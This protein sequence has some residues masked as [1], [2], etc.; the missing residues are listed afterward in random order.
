MTTSAAFPTDAPL[1]GTKLRA[2][3]SIATYR[4]RPRLSARLDAALEDR[5]RLTLLSAPP[6][7]GKTVAV[8]GWLEAR[9]VPHVWLSL[10]AADNDLARFVRYVAA[11]LRSVR[12]GAGEAAAGLFVPG[13]SPSADLVGATLLDVM[14]AGDDSFILVLDD[15]QAIGSEPI[16]HLVRFLI[17]RAPPFVHPVL[18]TREDPALP[19]ARWRA[20]GQLVEL[21]ANDLRY[22]DAEAA[23]Y[24]VDAGVALTPEHVGRLV[25][26]TEGWVAGLQLAAISLRGRP[27]PASLVNAFGGSQR[28]VL[29]YLADE[30]MGWVGDDLR[31]FL[32]ETSVAERFTAE[33][34]RELT[35]REDAEAL[36]ARAETSNLF[37]VPLDDER[38]WYRYHHLFADY[39]R[40][41]LGEDQRRGLDERAADYFDRQGLLAE[42]VEHALAASSLDAAIRLI[43]RG[44]RAAFEAGELATVLRWLE[45]IPPDRL[46]ASPELIWLRAWALFET[47]QLAA[48]IAVAEAHLATAGARGAAEGRL[49]VLLALMATVTRPDAEPLAREGLALVGDDASF[50]SLAL[51]AAGLAVLVRG[52]Y[53]SAAGTL[54]QAFGLARQAAHPMAVLTAVNP[55]GHALVLAGERGEA[56]ALCRQVLAQYADAQ[57]RPPPIA[58]SARV[59][60]GIARY[61]ANDLVEARRELEAGF[62]AAAGIGVGRPTLG[63]AVSYLALARLACGEPEAAL[64]SLRVSEGDARA[65]GMALPGLGGELEARIRIRQGD[66]AAAADWAER[67]TPEAPPGSPLLE[68]M[69]RSLDVT[70]ARVRLAQGRPEEARVLVARARAAHE[71]AGAVADLIS[72]EILAAAAAE[73]AGS[74]DEALRHLEGAIR[75]AAPGGYVRRFLDDGQP[76]A[77]L[78]PLV[79][80]TAPGFVDTLISAFAAEPTVVLPRSSRARG[81]SL[82]RGQGGELLEVLT[83][84]ELEVLRLMAAGASNAAIATGLGM[85]LGTAKWHV[86]HVLAKLDAANRT[87]ALVRAQQLGLA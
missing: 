54:R 87:Q 76:V 70:L 80:R 8:A 32:V 85:S 3:A 45:A 5:T 29:D 26:R 19:L 78:L 74:R 75:L 15:Y 47:G 10:D 30:V 71:A 18:L 51:Q 12:A 38:R 9:G 41:H 49:L 48:A 79:R 4:E 58:W 27:D 22:T 68:V 86:G 46:A 53:R 65:T 7:Y 83:A 23:A 62:A 67:A 40:S 13:S 1:V 82:W 52:D 72:S 11:A 25:E 43:E 31:T 81:P 21:R 69:R 64:E 44:G 33:L 20:H 28:F 35:G 39:L 34:C 77:H 2:P 55:L 84:R 36:L 66:V 57:G 61:E 24:L 59:V 63:W 73:A 14:A 56:E 37:V 6:G 17:E 60:L 16:H 42:A 50:R